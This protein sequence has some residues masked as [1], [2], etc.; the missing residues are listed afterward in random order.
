MASRAT[1]PPLE[2]EGGVDIA[3]RATDDRL[4]DWLD[5]HEELALWMLGGVAVVLRALLVAGSPR[6][7]GYV[8]DFYH[9]GI[10]ELYATGHLPA[11]TACW[12]CW[13]PPLFY[14]LGLP[15]YALGRWIHPGVVSADDPALAYVAAVPLAA[16]VLIVWYSI[17]LFRLFGLA[18]ADLVFATSLVLVLPCLFIASYS[19]EA[20]VVLA[21]IM[22]AFAFYLTRWFAGSPRDG[23]RDTAM[24]GLLAGLAAATKYSGLAAVA[25][26][27][28]IVGIR[29]AAGPKRA[30]AFRQMA[31]LLALCGT[32]G[33]WKYVDNVAR[34]GTPFF[35]NGSARQGFSMNGYYRERYEFGTFRLREAIALLGPDAPPGQ[36]T[37]LPAYRSVWTTLYA[38]TWGDM[39]FF[40]DPR[41]H[42]SGEPLYPPRHVPPWLAAAVLVGGLLPTLLA[43]IGLLGTARRRLALPLVVFTAITLAA[44]L[45]W[46]LGQELWALKTKYVL[47]LL[48]IY[49]LFAAL[50]LRRVRLDGPRWMAALVGVALL[51]LVLLTHVY[52]FRFAVG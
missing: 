29:A 46:V 38:M 42:G 47:F 26:G 21:A 48:P 13:H 31:V 22:V 5:R 19:L 23:W 30:K 9:Q 12:T 49:A 15:F 36:L 6:V 20:D 33:S 4:G 2:S 7:Y 18:G 37:F 8:Y 25:A 1:I 43:L 52:L 39:S 3:R 27:V 34:Y 40:S 17:R 35:A 16:S 14:L 41:R 24:L 50:G 32:I 45:H 51:A 44:Y 28:I 11:S 10:Q